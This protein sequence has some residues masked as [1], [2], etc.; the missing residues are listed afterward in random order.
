MINGSNIIAVD[1]NH[2]PQQQVSNIY[3]RNGSTL[4]KDFQYIEWGSKAKRRN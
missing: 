4:K 2:K 1:K 3:T